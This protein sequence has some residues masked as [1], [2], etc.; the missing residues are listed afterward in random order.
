MR[1]AP[2]ALAFHFDLEKS[3]RYA[4][5]SSRV[6]HPYP[7]NGEAC[8]VYTTVLVNILRGV[9]KEFLAKV[10]YEFPYEDQDLKARFRPYRGVEDW[11]YK[12][13]KEIKTSGYVID[14]LEAAFWSFFKSHSFREG[15]VRIVNL[16]SCIFMIELL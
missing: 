10:V 15:A 7:T 9:T 2:I 13:D 6:T 1:V 4:E 5:R 14:T 16:G 12:S 11:A 3:E 8:M